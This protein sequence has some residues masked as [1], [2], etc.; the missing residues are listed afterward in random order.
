MKNSKY[1]FVEYF[2]RRN[3]NWTAS[4]PCAAIFANKQTVIGWTNYFYQ[5]KQENLCIRVFH[6]QNKTG[7]VAPENVPITNLNN[8][9]KFLIVWVQN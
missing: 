5:Q 9:N 8:G 1:K 4:G 7:D 6:G 2:I 3:L